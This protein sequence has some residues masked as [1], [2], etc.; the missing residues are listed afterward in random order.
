LTE[1]P[2]LQFGASRFLQAHVDLFVSEALPRGEAMGRIAVAGT[3]GSPESRRRIAAFAA[4]KPYPVLVKG[5]SDGAVVD[6]IVEV[7]SVG[8]GVDAVTEWGELERL[9]IA[10]R[11]VL[12]NTADRGYETDPAD[13]LDAGPPRSFPAKLAKLLLARHRAGGDPI[14]LFPCELTPTNGQV[15][16][17]VV[18]DMLDRWQ[19]PANARNWIGNECVWV[20]SLVDRIVSE[21]VEPLGAVAEPYALWAIE[22]QPGLELPC[23]HAAIVVAA[24]LKPYERLKLFILNLG[25]TYLAEIWKR[26][27]GAPELTVREALADPTMRTKLDA[28]YE[29]EVLPVFVAIGVGDEAQA[30]LK[31]VIERFSNPFLNHRLSEILINHEAKKA[32]RF[33]GLIDLADTHGLRVKLPRLKAALTDGR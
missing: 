23:R 19:A 7:K 30:Y 21:P 17:G 3:T 13:R 16:R 6:E 24:D 11:C 26:E 31:T 8:A 22:D 28:L 29:D 1:F 18:L 33:G 25:H 2:I 14:I 5:L 10:A 9:F 12:S 32:R 20:N 27:G 15:L 4:A